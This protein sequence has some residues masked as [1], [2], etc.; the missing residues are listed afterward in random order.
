M[1]N[2]AKERIF[3]YNKSVSEI[4]YELGF[5]YPQHFTRLFKQRV[6]Q[7]PNEYRMLN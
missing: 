2:V 3:D 1:I 7:S 5:K 6:E 4:A